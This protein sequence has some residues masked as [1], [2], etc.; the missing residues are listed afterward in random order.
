M[1]KRVIGIVY[2]A[3]SGLLL[4]IKTQVVLSKP[5]D[6]RMDL[7][8]A[9]VQTP[10]QAP[11]ERIALGDRKIGYFSAI[12]QLRRQGAEVIVCADFTCDA[13]L[14]ELQAETTVPLISLMG[15]VKAQCQDEGVTRVGL[16]GTVQD[17]EAMRTLFAPLTVH[18]VGA[19]ATCECKSVQPSHR[20]R[21]L[22]QAG[23]QRVV[24]ACTGAFS[25]RVAL[26]DA[27]NPVMHPCA[28]VAQRL[29]ATRWCKHERGF[30]IGMIGGLGPAATVD[31]YDK[32]TRFTPATNDQEHIKV[33]VEQNPQIP[34]RT[35]C[36]LKGDVDPTLAMYNCA[37][38]LERDECDAIIV[39]C[40]TAHAFIPYLERH[41]KIPFINMQQATM[42]EILEKFGPEVRIGLLATS[43][44]I[45][46]GIYAEKAKAMGLAL[47][48]PDARHQAYV[49]SAIYGPKGAKAGFTTGVCREELLKAAAYMVRE[50]RCDCLIL[51]CTELPL[52]LDE[53]DNF[54]FE[55][56]NHVAFVDPTSALARKVVQLAM[57]KK[58]D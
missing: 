27:G 21:G 51:G 35:A 24:L 50:H 57:E 9:M 44:T 6:V 3:R 33:V 14:S 45:Q 15:A 4:P 5:E 53:C 36:L 38:R 26:R 55:D 19:D 48:T 11:S 56:G 43:G 34:D 17:Q 1:K 40:N 29:W 46:T 8:E 54:V 39:P 31:L 30:K 41:L 13:F 12:R 23:A 2:R 18:F 7:L 25:H 16:L 49:M 47:F 20:A 37:K 58:A 52:I 28:V 32:I 42:D 22:V 10:A